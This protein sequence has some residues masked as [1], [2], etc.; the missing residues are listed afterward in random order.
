MA[1]FNDSMT[2]AQRLNDSRI[3]TQRLNDNGHNPKEIVQTLKDN[4]S[5]NDNE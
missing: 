2:I 4:N 3:M 1:K 5:M